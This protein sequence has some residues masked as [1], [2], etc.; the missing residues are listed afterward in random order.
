VVVEK[1]RNEFDEIVRFKISLM[2]HEEDKERKREGFNFFFRHQN[3]VA[4]PLKESKHKEQ[5]CKEYGHIDEPHI[6]TSILKG[7]KSSKWEDK[8]LLYKIR[9]GQISK[10][11][12]NYLNEYFEAIHLSGVL[13]KVREYIDL[14]EKQINEVPLDDI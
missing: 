12:T 7:Y 1:I 5:I 13:S 10:K 2:G 4:L 3:F 11:K 8:S 9:T 14:L 6:K